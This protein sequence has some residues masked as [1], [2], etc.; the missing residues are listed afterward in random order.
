MG[1][2]QQRWSRRGLLAVTAG[3]LTASYLAVGFA[4][5][6]TLP[7]ARRV[8]KTRTLKL[9]GERTHARTIRTG[10]LRMTGFRT[11]PRRIISPPLR[12][13]GAPE[14]PRPPSKTNAKTKET[15]R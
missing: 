12:M 9:T 10:T 6:P 3:L 1:R 2:L 5:P 8:I 7:G 14:D 13:T 15:N 11:K 4:A